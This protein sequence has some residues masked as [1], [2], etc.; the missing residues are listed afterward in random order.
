MRNSVMSSLERTWERVLERVAERVTSEDL[1]QLIRPLRP[2]ALTPTELRLE[3][4]NKLSL[5]CVTDNYLGTLRDAI[6]S[7]AGPRQVLIDLPVRDQGELFP[8]SARRRPDRRLR[9]VH[10]TLNPKYTFANFVV[11]ASNQFAHAASKAVATQPGD[12]YN[13]LFIYGGV[14]L[15]KT[16]LVNAIGHQIL[17]RQTLVRI[18]YLSSDAFMN[19]LIASLRRDRM[20]DFKERFRRVDVLILDDVQLLA[21]R[22]RTQE[23]FF[24]TF[25]TLYDHRRQIVLTSGAY[26]SLTRRQISIDFAREILQM[27]L[28]PAQPTVSFDD[29]TRAVCDH[30]S[31]RPADLR[32]KRRSR[33][34]A[35]PRQ[36]AMYLCRRLLSASFPHIGELFERDHSTVIHATTVTERRIK[37][38]AAFQ[39]TVERLERTIRGQ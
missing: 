32:S 26:A 24:H 4:P 2:V 13:P 33:N 10:A 25:N 19:D 23:E 1:T 35:L 17:E 36:V 31:L 16:H 7:V 11:G 38:D 9:A 37:E 39:A 28:K 22:E 30:F 6:S 8:D 27:V 12:H 29:I 3:A 21:G 18:A 14:G 34:V 5:L 20:S 15:G